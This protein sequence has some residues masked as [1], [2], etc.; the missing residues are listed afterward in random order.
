MASC[1]FSIRT[2]TYDDTPDDFQLRDFSL[3]EE[4]V[5]L[6]VGSRPWW[7]QCLPAVEPQARAGH[8]DT[9]SLAPAV[10]CPGVGGQGGGP[11]QGLTHW[12]GQSVHIP[13]L[14]VSLLTSTVSRYP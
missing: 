11:W 9:Q 7:S 6:K 1:D 8:G 13:A 5:K 10:L 2:Y 14:T 3:P 4:D 12:S